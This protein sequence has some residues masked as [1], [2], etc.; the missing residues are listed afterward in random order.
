[1][2][3]NQISIEQ[4]ARE[5]ETAQRQYVDVLDSYEAGRAD[6]LLLKAVAGLLSQAHYKLKQAHLDT[7]RGTAIAPAG[8]GAHVEASESEP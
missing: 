1:V 3:T 2:E 7:N 6:L 5:L 4:A 8:S